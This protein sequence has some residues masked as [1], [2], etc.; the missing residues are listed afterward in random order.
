MNSKTKLAWEDLLSFKDDAELIE[1]EADMISLRIA[2]EIK[3]VLEDK[4]ISKKDFAKLIDT[5]PAYVTQVLR[6]DKKINMVFLAKVV[7]KLN[8][9]F[10]FR[11]KDHDDTESANWDEVFQVAQESALPR[12]KVIELTDYLKYAEK[13]S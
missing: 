4:H 6:G 1:H 11:F 12:C 13:V 2:L 10:D 9:T 5:S 3:R 8:I 7:K